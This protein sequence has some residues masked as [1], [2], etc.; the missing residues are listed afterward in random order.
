MPT[1][2]A[3]KTPRR[4][5]H[6]ER[7]EQSERRMFDATETL[8]LELGTQKTTLKE[9]GEKAG[10]SRGLAHARFGSKEELFLRLADRCRSIW[11]EELER[12]EGNKRG[13]AAFMSRLD[14]MA[15]YGARYPED[16]RVMYILWFECVGSPSAMKSGLERFHQQA[17]NDIRRLIEQA[18]QAGEIADDIDPEHFA[19]HFT[20]TM[21]GISYQWVVNPEAV[22]I[23]QLI[24]DIRRQMLLVLRPTSGAHN[25]PA[26]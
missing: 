9:V 19:M 3:K 8:I 5:S 1:S 4:R 22:N 18:L 14:A 16:A 24:D 10:Y 25:N 21:F 26:S 23:A 7:V 20:A 12:A 11:L 2:S 13:L 15:S 17:R 6:T